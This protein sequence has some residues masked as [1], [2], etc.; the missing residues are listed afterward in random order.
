M[1]SISLALCS[2]ITPARFI[3]M[4]MG[5]ATAG[6]IHA[7]KA[8]EKTIRAGGR[9]SRKTDP[10]ANTSARNAMVLLRIFT[11]LTPLELNYNF[12]YTLQV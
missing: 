3:K 5:M 1:L 9:C 2:C 10:K 11:F 7:W 6:S 12:L 4:N 8:M